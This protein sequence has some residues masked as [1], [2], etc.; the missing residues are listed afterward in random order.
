MTYPHHLASPQHACLYRYDKLHHVKEFLDMCTA[1]CL[2]DCFSAGLQHLYHQQRPF[3]TLMFFHYTCAK[4]SV[5]RSDLRSSTI[6]SGYCSLSVKVSSS[7]MCFQQYIELALRCQ[8]GLRAGAQLVAILPLPCGQAAGS[9]NL[10]VSTK[11][12]VDLL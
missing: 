1:P 12:T 4:P 7:I 6:D 3:H 10:D 8:E 2:S 11:L 5:T 9:P